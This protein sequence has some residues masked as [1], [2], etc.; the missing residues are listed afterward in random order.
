MNIEN[1]SAFLASVALAFFIAD[2]IA[3]LIQLHGAKT[4]KEISGRGLVIRILGISFFVLRF[5]V[6]GDEILF[7]GQ[8]IFFVIMLTYTL[9]AFKYKKND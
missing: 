3:Q 1:I 5:A 8:F 7:I 6:I 4:S 2:A 9:L